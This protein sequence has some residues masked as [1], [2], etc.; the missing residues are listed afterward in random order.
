[1]KEAEKFLKSVKFKCNFEDREKSFQTG[2]PGKSKDFLESN[3]YLP[4]SG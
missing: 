2:S 4:S 1:M 3:R